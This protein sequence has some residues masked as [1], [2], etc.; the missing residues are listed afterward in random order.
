MAQDQILPLGPCKLPFVTYLLK[1]KLV[2]SLTD[3]P[4]HQ[5]KLIELFL[6]PTLR[7]F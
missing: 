7:H 4:G 5:N 6:V 1:V 3:F 2:I